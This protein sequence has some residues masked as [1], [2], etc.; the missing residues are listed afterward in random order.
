MNYIEIHKDEKKPMKNFVREKIKN[1]LENY[2]LQGKAISPDWINLISL[3]VSNEILCPT[4]REII[5]MFG[6]LSKKTGEIVNKNKDIKEMV[7][8]CLKNIFIEILSLC[9]DNKREE[10]INNELFDSQ[11]KIIEFIKDPS[12]YIYNS[13]ENNLCN[14]IK[15]EIIENNLIKVIDTYQN[16]SIE[17]I[18]KLDNK[19]EDIN[20]NLMKKYE[21]IN[22]NNDLFLLEGKTEEIMKLIN[23]YNELIDIIKNKNK[24]SNICNIQITS[25]EMNEINDIKTQ[26]EKNKLNNIIY[27]EELLSYYKIPINYNKLK[28]NNLELFYKNKIFLFPQ[29]EENIKEIY[30]I[31]NEITEDFRN[32]FQIKKNSLSESG[33]APNAEYLNIINFSINIKEILDFEKVEKKIIKKLNSSRKKIRLFLINEYFPHNNSNYKKNNKHKNKKNKNN[34]GNNEISYP[35]ILFN[36][37]KWETLKRYI[38]DLKES[39]K[40]LN[41]QYILFI[42]KNKEK[43]NNECIQ[44]LR[45]KLVELS[46]QLNEIK[47]CLII[48]KNF[49]EVISKLLKD[50]KFLFDQIFNE[51]NKLE[52]KLIE[53]ICK[54]VDQFLKLEEKNIF[55]ENY[56]FPQLPEKTEKIDIDFSKLNYNME[57]LYVPMINLNCDSQN[58]ICSHKI[59]NIYLGEVCPYYYDGPI[60]IKIISFVKDIIKNS[61]TKYKLFQISRDENKEELTAKDKEKL[62]T[63]K[64]ETFPGENIE[65][66]VNI[67]KD[68]DDE[69]KIEGELKL[70]ASTIKPLKLNLN[71]FFKIISNKIMLESNKYNLINEPDRQGKN[72]LFDQYYRLNANELENGEIIEFSIKNFIKNDFI[73]FSPSLNSLDKNTCEKPNIDFKC[74]TGSL[75]IYLPEYDNY[76]S[77]ETPRI[78]CEVVIYFNEQFQIIILIDALINT[79]IFSLKMYDYFLKDYVENESTIYLNNS[80]IQIF[81]NEN[82]FIILD[83]KLY[84][85]SK[86][87]KL[88]MSFYNEHIDKISINFE[89]QELE[90][91]NPIT[92]FKALLTFEKNFHFHKSNDKKE[93]NIYF[94]IDKKRIKFHI[95]I[96]KY[97][98]NSDNLNLEENKG[99]EGNEKIGFYYYNVNPFE[100]V[101]FISFHYNENKL[102]YPL[103]LKI[104][105]I[106]LYKNGLQTLK[107][108][109]NDLITKNNLNYIDFNYSIPIIGI[110]GDD[111]F[112]LVSFNT[113][114]NEY[115]KYLDLFTPNKVQEMIKNQGLSSFLKSLQKR[116]S[117]NQGF[118]KKIVFQYKN[119]D[120]EIKISNEQNILV[121]KEISDSINREIIN[122]EHN[123]II[124]NKYDY[125]N[126]SFFYLAQW[127]LFSK[128]NYLIYQIKNIFPHQINI[129]LKD[130][131][132]SFEEHY[133]KNLSF[134]DINYFAKLKEIFF[135]KYKNNGYRYG[136]E[137]RALKDK[138]K[139]LLFDLYQNKNEKQ[140]EVAIPKKIE[141][142]EKDLK[143]LIKLKEKY[144]KEESKDISKKTIGKKFLLQGIDSKLLENNY[145]IQE[146]QNF[147]DKNQ[148][149]VIDNNMKIKFPKIINKFHKS[150][151]LKDL[152]NQYEQYIIGARVFPSFLSKA[153]LNNDKKKIE[154]S[155]KNFNL[156]YSF[157]KNTIQ[158][159]GHSLLNEKIMEYN[160]SFEKTIQKLKKAGVKFDNINLLKD[161][162]ED[163]NQEISYI[164][165]PPPI[166]V[167]QTFDKWEEKI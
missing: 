79:N 81:K 52:T 167:K 126:D 89:N 62:L 97:Q 135:E 90:I 45:E 68:F 66:Y 12:K 109:K 83:F 120:K 29:E 159:K 23:K 37:I 104:S 150:F 22:I 34:K 155:Y 134:N 94:N 51:I 141:N 110:C 87:E 36:G 166:N 63:V 95:Y 71:I 130:F 106:Y 9:L 13:I 21:K 115:F 77:D 3:K 88:K 111:W 162:K 86:K 39:L 10:T 6:E 108:D 1:F 137:F 24:N 16:E 57:D 92:N 74:E 149:L 26:I 101:P 127:N 118:I 140:I 42:E 122:Y 138:Q 98:K 129:Q 28:N 75:K 139:K 7:F 8:I 70:E 48:D 56:S 46:D 41:K 114:D 100:A 25:I 54:Q 50:Y 91:I 153:L 67:P 164:I 142:Y 31:I 93:F 152:R 102:F 64:S 148:Q 58:F 128:N 143:N 123:R 60:I 80:S 136:L 133:P 30:V 158:Y 147:K 72:G 43:I 117:F 107:Y 2:I 44:N 112:P 15:K 156:L 105:I 32:N 84:T 161:I 165:Y 124:N 38:S 47:K 33:E 85:N 40:D 5:K 17:I 151:S 59:L 27:G 99:K 163:K 103:G 14:T 61:I 53:I 82:Q 119:I 132:S 157:Y 121:Y 69:I 55:V 19:I 145:I 73:N 76:S 154:K 131:Y 49:D 78:N 160:I 4:I 125:Y 20:E 116:Y 35:E 11:N 146:E 96:K 18:E 113:N 65:I 144:E